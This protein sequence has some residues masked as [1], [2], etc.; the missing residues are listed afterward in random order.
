MRSFAIAAVLGFV[1][2]SA[3]AADMPVKTPPLSNVYPTKSCGFFYGANAEGSTGIVN[4][5]PAGTV[6]I[7]GDVGLLVGWACPTAPVPWFV[8]AD[9]DFQNLNAGNAGFSMKGPA[10]FSQ[11]AAIQTPLFSY[12]GQ[13][14][15][16]GQ[17][18]IP[19]PV[20]PPGITLSGQP[21]NYVGLMVTEDDISTSFNLASNREWLVSYGLR[22]GSLFNATAA[23]VAGS[24]T[25]P[26]P[27]VID[28]YAAVLWQSD[29][30]CVGTT[31]VVCPKMGDRFVAGLDVKM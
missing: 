20:L 1:A 19:T 27:V 2:G 11:T 25:K 13:W 10:H 28:T 14:L 23:P 6:Q 3:I 9:F 24:T 12:I 15:N 5:A 17:N 26:L 21:Q 31:K 30:T 29:S 7:G 22:V 18:N 4:G 16:V 8:Q